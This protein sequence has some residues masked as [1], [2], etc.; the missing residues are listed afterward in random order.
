MM[1]LRNL[2]LVLAAAVAA[3]ACSKTG[4]APTDFGVNVTVDATMLTT[5]ERAKITTDKLTVVSDKAGAAPVVRMLPDLPKAIQ[6]GTVRFHY[7]PGADITASNSLSFGLDVMDANNAIIASGAAGPKMLATNAVELKI[8]L[9]TGAGDGGTSD[10][11]SDVGAGEVVNPNGKANGL[12]C[13]TDDEC[14]TAFCTDGVCCNER[15]KDVCASCNLTGTKGICTA[16]PMGMDPEMECVA[17]IPIEPDAGAAP[18]S[19]STD[20]GSPE[21][22]SPEAGASGDGSAPDGSTDADQSDAVV[23]NTPDGGFMTMPKA[24]GGT[25][26]GGRSCKFPTST[27]SCGTAF[28]NTPGQAA[29]F[30]CDGMGSC[31]PALLSCADYRCVDS[32][33]VCGT[34][35]TST[36]DCLASDFCGGDKKC[37]SKKGN[38]VACVT[39]DECSSANCIAG[40][41][42]GVCC[43]TAC[44]SPLTCT[45][46][47]PRGPVPVP[48]RD[49]RRGRRLPGLLP[50]HRRRRL[51]RQG[52][53]G[54]DRG[55]PA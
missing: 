47:G 40:A 44:D 21:A 27:T 12:A 19:G 32:T 36:A 31:S 9:S 17:V 46:A 52:R 20:A 25:C 13:V 26:G 11:N 53:H 1:R 54:H 4:S 41:T 15:C 45:M 51:R 5:A 3:A 29:S 42:G 2:A 55:R 39:P 23:F 30:V 48:G 18:D 35:C 24:C 28:C 37:T 34:T 6:G 50:R 49:V 16:Y 33:G 43:N 10:T 8:V 14:G 22:G 38:G 7:K